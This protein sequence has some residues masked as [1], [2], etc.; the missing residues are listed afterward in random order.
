ML[1]LLSNPSPVFIVEDEEPIAHALTCIVEDAGYQAMMAVHGRQALDLAHQ[2][3]PDLIITEFMAPYFN[4]VDAMRAIRQEAQTQ[5]KAAPPVMIMSDKD[6]PRLRNL[7]ADATISKPF[8]NS[9]VE[10][11]LRRFLGARHDA[12]PAA[13]G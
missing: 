2:R 10:A 3:W 1:Q 11:M 9:E 8:E 5:G 13:E 12:Q 6:K 4:G 7:G